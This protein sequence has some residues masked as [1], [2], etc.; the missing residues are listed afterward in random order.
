MSKVIFFGGDYNYCFY[1]MKNDKSRYIR[2]FSS[3]LRTLLL[4]Y[5]IFNLNV[6]YGTI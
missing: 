1:V 3:L 6:K 2:Y 4:T 5:A